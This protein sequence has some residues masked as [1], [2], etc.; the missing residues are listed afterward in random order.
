MKWFRILIPGVWGESLH[1][2]TIHKQTH[3]IT[4][5]QSHLYSPSS[6]R[7]GGGGGEMT[8]E[9]KVEGVK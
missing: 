8:W 7:R 3:V 2:Y 5:T 9:E 1:T 6:E 4:L